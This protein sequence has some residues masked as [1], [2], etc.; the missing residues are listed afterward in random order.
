VQAATTTPIRPGAGGVG[1]ARSRQ[2]WQWE[3]GHGRTCWRVSV[4]VPIW[5][6][7]STSDARRFQ[8]RWQPMVPLAGIPPRI[9][10]SPRA[11]CV[12][13]ARL[14]TIL[15]GIS[16][17]VPCEGVKTWRRPRLAGRNGQ[18]VRL[19]LQ[20]SLR[21]GRPQASLREHMAI[22]T[23]IT[24]RQ[25]D[26]AEQAMHRHLHSVMR[27]LIDHHQPGNTTRQT[28]GRVIM[29]DDPVGRSGEAGTSAVSQHETVP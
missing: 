8:I 23:A 3:T 26:E 19:Q 29:N 12:R 21:P 10:W 13:P 1:R 28:G 7:A 16:R 6:P 2:R 14:L 24:G 27:A 15:L 11:V 5:C 18:L 20:L 17:I 22:I 4:A 25:P 9:F